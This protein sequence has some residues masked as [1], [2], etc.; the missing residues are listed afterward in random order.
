[1]HVWKRRTEL[2]VSFSCLLHFCALAGEEN[3]DR[4]PHSGLFSQNII[5]MFLYA[6]MLRW[7]RPAAHKLSVYRTSGFLFTLWM[8]SGSVQG[9]RISV[10]IAKSFTMGFPSFFSFLFSLCVCVCYLLFAF[11]RISG[12]YYHALFVFCRVLGP[13]CYLFAFCRI[14]ES[15]YYVLF[16]LCMISES[17]YYVLFALCRISELVYYVLFVLCRI[18]ELVYYVMF[19]LC[20]ISELVY[21][22]MFALC[23]ISGSVY[24]PL[25]VLCKVLGWACCLLFAFCRI[26]GSMCLGSSLFQRIRINGWQTLFCTTHAPHAMTSSSPTSLAWMGS[27]EVL[28]IVC[29]CVCSKDKVCLSA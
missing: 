17:V 23:R 16:A 21:S 12:S 3:M 18:S 13:A 9:L 2:C 7:F 27:S 26:S 11:C 28:K 19:S 25:F 8:C 20:R 10:W 29:V 1:M 6:A 4:T 5:M 22:V 24:Y 15:V 14:S